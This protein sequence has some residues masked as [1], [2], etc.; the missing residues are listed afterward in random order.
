MSLIAPASSAL[1]AATQ[2]LNSGDG[3]TYVM[4]DKKVTQDLPKVIAKLDVQPT[5][6]W[7]EMRR[8]SLPTRVTLNQQY[9]DE[10]ETT[11]KERAI[12]SKRLTGPEALAAQFQVEIPKR[13]L[14]L[15]EMA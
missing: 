5:S 2:T 14:L 3:T 15:N 4:I 9:A 7:K 13:L 1:H 8:S 10:F 12:P 6:L 11:M